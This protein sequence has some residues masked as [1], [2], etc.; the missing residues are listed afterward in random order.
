MKPLTLNLAL[1]GGGAHGAFTWGMLDRLLQQDD[2]RFDAISG[3]SAGAMNAVLLAAGWQQGG[4]DGARELLSRF[5]HGLMLPGPLDPAGL[6][7]HW[8]L[9]WRDMTKHLS[10]Y[11]L[12]PFDINPLR[13]LLE[14]LIDFEQLRRASPCRLFIAAT[15]VDSGRLRLFRE[16]E[17]T[18]DHLL[19][20]A[21][22]PELYQAVEIDGVAHWDGGFVGNPVVYPLVFDSAA[23]DLLLLL[24]HPRR[25]SG[26]PTSAQAIADRVAELGFQ[27]TFMREMHALAVMRR[28]L[29][30]R[31]WLWGRTERRVRRLRLHLVDP[32]E[33]LSSLHRSSKLDTRRSFLLALYQR[34]AA[35]M[36]EWLATHG[37]LL[38]RRGSCDLETE[39]LCTPTPGPGP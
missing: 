3:T 24:L 32:D 34:G 4:R 30:G 7:Q 35:R 11:D 10:P 29:R 33:R 2:V 21:C 6:G 5:W 27:T 28:R 8:S 18:A 17:L 14:E 16:Q 39:F 23:A 31:P 9:W 22:L 25:Q 37:R 26:A 1:Q 12:N 36:E 20:S 15:E 19:A 38:G 13:H